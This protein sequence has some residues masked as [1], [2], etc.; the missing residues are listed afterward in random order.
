M[1]LQRSISNVETIDNMSTELGGQMIDCGKGGVAV[2]DNMKIYH[3]SLNVSCSIFEY[4]LQNLW[5][6]PH[7]PV[8]GPFVP[9]KVL[10]HIID[11]II[12]NVL[13]ANNKGDNIPIKLLSSYSLLLFTLINIPL[14]S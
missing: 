4:E 1:C 7:L 14:L 5:F 13:L 3:A 10:S 12:S 6:L 9:I 2:G 11:L 8:Q